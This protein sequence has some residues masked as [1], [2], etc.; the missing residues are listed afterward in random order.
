[1]ASSTTRRSSGRSG[2]GL[3][4][5]G[6]TLSLACFGATAYVFIKF[7]VRKEKRLH[8]TPFHR[9]RE[10]SL[11]EI[12]SKETSS[13]RNIQQVSDRGRTALVHPVPYL[14]Q[15]VACFQASTFFF[16]RLLLWRLHCWR[17]SLFASILS[18]IRGCRNHLRGWRFFSLSG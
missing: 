11:S 16:R 4:A 7:V 13:L 12:I 5:E 2:S 6:M 8:D 10:K 9:R 15:F 17:F 3:I 14:K 1:M 18:G